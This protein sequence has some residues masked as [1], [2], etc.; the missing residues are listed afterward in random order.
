MNCEQTILEPLQ[1]PINAIELE[2]STANLK[3]Y[4]CEDLSPLDYG[5]LE[6]R[7]IYGDWTG[8]APACK[9]PSQCDIRP[10][11]SAGFS[12]YQSD[13]GINVVTN[14]IEDTVSIRLIC[15]DNSRLN[16]ISVTDDLIETCSN[17]STITSDYFCVYDPS[18]QNPR[19]V[20][21]PLTEA[22]WMGKTV[23][24]FGIELQTSS[25]VIPFS[26]YISNNEGSVILEHQGYFFVGDSFSLFMML[27]FPALPTQELEIL[28]W[29]YAQ[30]NVT[31][32]VELPDRD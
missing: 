28:K 25:E 20:I 19:L 24:K 9:A 5:S 13:T 21:T 10:L 14:Y 16:D 12:I 22:E 6:R 31:S 27:Q 26:Y 11:L 7:C 23:R 17:G 4:Q 15:S 18:T 1:V 32:S 8:R 2:L 29:R 30:L 3:T